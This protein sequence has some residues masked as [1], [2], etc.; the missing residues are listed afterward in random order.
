MKKIVGYIRDFVKQDFHAG[1]YAWTFIF[2]AAAII[3]NTQFHIERKMLNGL[4]HTVTCMAAYFVFYAVAYYAV[5]VPQALLLKA[6]YLHNKMFWIKSLLFLLLLGV[7][8]GFYYHKEYIQSIQGISSGEKY[9]LSTLSN[10]MYRYLLYIP[11]LLFA[12]LAFDRGRDGF[13]GL[14]LKKFDPKPYLFFLLL[15]AP[16]LFAL[17]FQA[18]FQRSY[19]QMKPWRI[20]GAFGWEAWELSSVFEFFYLSDFVFVELIFRGA[21]VIGMTSVMGRHAVLPMIAAYCFLHFGKPAAEA[22]GSV[23]GGYLLGIIALNSRNILGGY[24]IH[25]G[26]AF[27][28]EMMGLLQY[29]V[30]KK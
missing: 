11:V 17:S 23:F 26:L 20:P 8:G 4:G 12:K 1:L 3:L 13:Y 28:M 5:A 10:N 18:D 14:A 22:I 19:P 16:V 30:F 2:L 7:D 15:I 29:Y 21:L 25:M 6:G 9:Y 27:L 24:A